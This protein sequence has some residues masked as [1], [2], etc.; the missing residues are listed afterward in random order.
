MSLTSLDMF[1]HIDD[2]FASATVIR[3]STTGG[4]YVNGKWVAGTTSTSSHVAN[5]QPL[6][7]KE[8]NHLSIGGDRIKDYRKLY[9]NDGSAGEIIEADTYT[10]PGVDGTFKTFML[11]NRVPFGRNYCKIVVARIDPS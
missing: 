2:V 4:A 9:I 7:A 1:G 8:A 3:T 10:I 5:I 11:D 6:N